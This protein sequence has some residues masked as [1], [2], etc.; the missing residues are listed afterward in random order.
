M[1]RTASLILRSRV[2]EWLRKTLRASCW[3]MVLAPWRIPPAATLEVDRAQ[4]ARQVHAPVAEEPAI[5][6]GEH[7]LAHHFGNLRQ[8][9]RDC[10][11]R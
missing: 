11:S 5:L 1:A 3:V 6:R 2:W 10:G 8:R 7:R 9:H 4:H